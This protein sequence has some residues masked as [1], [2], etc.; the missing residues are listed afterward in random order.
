MSYLYQAMPL[1]SA[2]P[3]CSGIPIGSLTPH[4][5]NGVKNCHS[6]PVPLAM[7]A[8]SMQIEFQI[9]WNPDAVTDS[10]DV[11]VMLTGVLNTALM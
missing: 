7:Q 9:R 1:A 8:E 2:E 10:S 4:F 6:V 11:K 5:S 3:A